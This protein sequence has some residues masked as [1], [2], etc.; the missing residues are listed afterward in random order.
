MED[1]SGAER[2]GYSMEKTPVSHR[3]PGAKLAVV[4][5]VGLVLGIPLLMVGALRWERE[6]R[7][8][9]VESEVASLAGREQTVYGPFLEVPYA[10]PV[11]NRTVDAQGKLI[12]HMESRRGLLILS[13]DEADYSVEQV[14]KSLHRA[15]YEVPS[16]TSTIEVS[17]KFGAPSLPRLPDNSRL[18]W[19]ESQWLMGVTDLRGVVS[20][21]VKSASEELSFET[22]NKHSGWDNLG[23]PTTLEAALSEP[24]I[25]KGKL[26]VRGVGGLKLTPAGR[27]TRVKMRS[28]WPHPAFD[29]SQIPLHREID[30]SG[31]TAN[32]SVSSFARMIPSA[33]LDNLY[34]HDQTFGVRLVNPANGYAQ[35]GRSLKY[36]IIFVGL[37]LAVFLMLELSSGLQIHPAQYALVGLA[38][39]CFYLLLLAFSEHTSVAA[40][41]AIGGAATTL[42]TGLY[43]LWTFGRWGFGVG[44]LVGTAVSYS[45]QYALVQLEDHALLI[46]SCLVFGVVAALMYATRKVRWYRSEGM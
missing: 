27:T 8:Q 31:F 15:I 38:Q 20:L 3:S 45:F 41:Y 16:Q 29:G 28:D 22:R 12:E 5:A 39:V 30:D 14:T 19:E 36:A 35:V 34:I 2:L 10:Y 11:H 32:W 46:G 42:L 43:A 17:A 18:L 25:V 7:F 33:A 6:A 24:L 37:V 9:A 4:G 21:E 1:G 40:S 26:V 23:A 13:P 44:V